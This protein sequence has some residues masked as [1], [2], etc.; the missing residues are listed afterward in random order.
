MEA[1]DEQY[2]SQLK[3]LLPPGVAFPRETGSALA[4]ILGGLSPEL[5]RVHNRALDLFDEA[6]PRAAN[7]LIG[8]WERVAGLP[9]ACVSAEIADTIAERQAAVVQRLTAQ[10]GQTPQFLVDLAAAFGF[11]ITVTELLPSR[12]GQ[13]VFG[14]EFRPQETVFEWHVEAEATTVTESVFGQAQFGEPFGGI[15]SNAALECVI[16]RAAPA[17]TKVQFIFGV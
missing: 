7:Q 2:I 5:A 10:G 11:V 17:H 4:K 14:T 1:T 6:D 9:D 12:F 8:E 16:L 13:A 3:A 15:A